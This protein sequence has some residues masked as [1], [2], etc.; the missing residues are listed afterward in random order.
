M[1]KCKNTSI[2][3]HLAVWA[4][5]LALVA[6]WGSDSSFASTNFTLLQAATFEEKNKTFK[7]LEKLQIWL[8]LQAE[9]LSGWLDDDSAGDAD[10]EDG[11]DG[12]G[13]SW[14]PTVWSSWSS[15]SSSV[16]S[17]SSS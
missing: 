9:S 2:I 3:G 1:K 14:G 12:K 10:D 15:S 5:S 17:S 11:D 16:S 4:V 8:H 13:E 6:L 7:M